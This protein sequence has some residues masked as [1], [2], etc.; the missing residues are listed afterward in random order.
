MCSLIKIIH[1][2]SP[3][4]VFTSRVAGVAAASVWVKGMEGSPTSYLR[5]LLLVLAH[6]LGT[7]G[8]GFHRCV[9]RPADCVLRAEHIFVSCCG[10][11][12][13]ARLGWA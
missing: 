12:L 9:L 2:V 3:L 10:V 11:A 5:S 4:I 7:S 6:G 1:E 8:W 13:I